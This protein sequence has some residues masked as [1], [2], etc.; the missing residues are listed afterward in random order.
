MSGD[1]PDDVPNPSSPACLMHEVDAVYMGLSPSGGDI[2]AW[3]QGERKRLIEARMALSFA[4]RDA[5][6]ADI[7][8]KLDGIIGD[9]AGRTVS[10]FWP[11]RGEPDLRNWMAAISTKGGTTLLPVVVGKGKPLTFRSWAPGEKLEPG[12]WNIPMPAGGVEAIPDIVI[13]P[14]VGFDASCFRLGYGGGFF[15][16]TLAQFRHSPLVIGVGYEQQAIPSIRPQP[17]DIPMDIIVTERRVR[18]R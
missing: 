17:H 18:Y 6:A 5:Y 11:F 15:D 3:R 1:D 14:V 10:A 9:T 12:V 4:T 8:A 16:R 13:A 7:A 2:A